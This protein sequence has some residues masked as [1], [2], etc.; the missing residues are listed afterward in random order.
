MRLD[1]L[2]HNLSNAAFAESKNRFE[3]LDKNKNRDHSLLQ[4]GGFG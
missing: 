1:G 4:T 2:I 3:D